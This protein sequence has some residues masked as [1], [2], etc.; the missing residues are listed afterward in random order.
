[1][2]AMASEDTDAFLEIFSDPKVMQSFDG[3]LFDR[4]Q[5]EQWVQ[6]NLAHQ[7]KYGYGLFSVILKEKNTLIGDCGLE[8]MVIDGHP[9]V[10][11]GYDIHSGYWN[12]GFATQAAG[13]VRDFAFQELQIPRLISLIRPAN[14]A[15]LRVSEKIG[16][17]KEK[18]ILRGE[19]TYW[20]YALSRDDR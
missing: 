2:R 18:E 11:L 10:E 14:I 3:E 5:M 8:H 4:R 6:R 15:S 7:E 16:M 20:I 17:A 13:A 9:E 12:R 1:M 19:V